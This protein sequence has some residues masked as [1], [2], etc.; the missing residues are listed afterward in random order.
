MQA[1]AVFGGGELE[2][3]LAGG[4]VEDELVMPTLP[5][6]AAV[7]LLRLEAGEAGIVG[8]GAVLLAGEVGGGVGAGLAAAAGDAVAL[9]IGLT[10][11]VVGAANDDGPVDV[12]VL[13]GDKH[14][15][16]GARGEVAAPVG[17]G[18]RAHDAQP[19]A[20]AVVG[21][22]VVR[23]GGVWVAAAGSGA[24]LPRKLDAHAQVAVGVG[25]RAV[26]NN[27][28]GE[29]SGLGGPRVDVPAMGVGQQGPPGDIG[30]D[31]GELVAVE[32]Y[33]RAAGFVAGRRAAAGLGGAEVV[34]GLVADLGD[35]EAALGQGIAFVL[36]VFEEGEAVAGGAGADGAFAGELFHPGVERLALVADHAFAMGGALPGV[37]AGVVPGHGARHRAVLDAAGCALRAPGQAAVV[38]AA[39]LGMNSK[40][41]MNCSDSGALRHH[42]VARLFV[43]PTTTPDAA[44]PA[45]RDRQARWHIHPPPTEAIA[46]FCSCA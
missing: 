6:A 46:V 3:G 22:G 30:A 9:G 19:D 14:F 26:A 31:G 2:P 34:A 18:H 11:A 43:A 33:G 38:P 27:D 29:Q 17:A 35:Q 25:G 1:A 44:H 23:A 45:P 40:M 28:G 16:A 21:R 42:S 20:E 7:E 36:G 4:V 8:V 12:A 13:E 24:A 39:G 15:L 37:L 10:L 32:V 41:N 5:A